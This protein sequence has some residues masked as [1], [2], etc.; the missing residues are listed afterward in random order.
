MERIRDKKAGR[1]IS[2]YVILKGSRRAAT[3][4]VLRGSGGGVQVDIW[5]EPEA[6][7]R[8]RAALLKAGGKLPPKPGEY[9]EPMALQQAK[10]G[11][12]GYDKFTACLSGM[13][14]DGHKLTDHCGE[15]LK[16]PRGKK[17]FP[18]GFKA[19]EGYRL[20]NFGTFQE[21]TGRKVDPW[22]PETET[23]ERVNG[24][25]DCYRQAGLQYLAA[26]GYT[27]IEA[28]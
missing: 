16:K 24:Y 11:G 21:S 4:H 2:A 7:S 13:W 12:H 28:L 8:S 6:A 10:A 18:Q 17:Y 25:S 26:V 5:Q 23:G 9:I 3:V 20:A 19:P 22:A 27:V 14:V 1:A 15:S